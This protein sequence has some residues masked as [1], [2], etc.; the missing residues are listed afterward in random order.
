MKFLILAAMML[1]L[2][3]CIHN[4]VPYPV[5]KG[6]VV[7]FEVDGQK[8]ST[9]NSAKQTIDVVLDEA[10][11]ISKVA[12]KR[13]QITDNATIDI[14]TTQMLNLSGVLGFT[15]TTY[16]DYSWQIHATQPIE[17][18]FRVENQVGESNIDALNKKVVVYIPQSQAIDKIKVVDAKLGPANSTTLPD[19]KLV[20]NFTRSQI[21]LVKYLNVTEEWTVYVLKKP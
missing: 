12:V 21:F 15:I 19:P 14:D 20:T 9:I 6:E 16:Q 5:V 1:S 2:T 17:R 7:V 4:D 10:T 13:F 3:C 18:R 8:S 11:D